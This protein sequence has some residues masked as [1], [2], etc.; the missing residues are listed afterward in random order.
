MSEDSIARR[1]ARYTCQFDFDMLSDKVLACV[2]G[3]YNASSVKPAK[4][5]SEYFSVTFSHQIGT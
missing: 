1:L 5:F 2:L 4:N 3:A